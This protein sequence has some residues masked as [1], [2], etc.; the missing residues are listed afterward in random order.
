MFSFSFLFPSY[1][2][3]VTFRVVSIVSDGRNQSSFAFFYVV[4]ELLYVCINAVFDAGKSSTSLF[5]GT[6][7]LSRSSLGCN[8]SCMVINFLVLWPICLSSSL[9]HLRKGPEYLTRGTAQVFIPLI[10]FLL[11]SLVSSSFLVLLRYSFWILSFI[12]TCLMVSASNIS[13]YLYVS[14]SANVLIL[15]RFGSSI[16]SV[17]CRLP[18]L[19]TSRAHFSVPNSIPMS[20]QYILTVYYYYYYYYYYLLFESFSHHFYHYYYYH[21]YYCHNRELA[22][23]PG[24]QGLI[25]GRVAPKTQKIILDASLFNTQH[26]VKINSRRSYPGKE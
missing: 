18:F 22:N 15:F 5:L 14:F 25:P 3:S 6:Y 12:S 19:M 4:F 20:W 9:V 21:Y 7:S 2:H 13:Q 16:P 8:A 1:Y 26:M 23:G 11:E 17:T 10:R 24:D